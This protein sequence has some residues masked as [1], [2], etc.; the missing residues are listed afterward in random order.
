VNKGLAAF[1][2]QLGRRLGYAVTAG[3]VFSSSESLDPG[4]P[5]PDSGNNIITDDGTVFVT[6]DGSRIIYST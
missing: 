4:D 5:A 3:A 1:S 6:S 2:N